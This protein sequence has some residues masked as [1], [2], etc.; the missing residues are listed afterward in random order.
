MSQIIT[1]NFTH[2]AKGDTELFS[3][4]SL[5]SQ[6]KLCRNFL[7]IIDYKSSKEWFHPVN[8]QS[9]RNL[10]DNCTL[11]RTNSTIRIFKDKKC[12]VYIF[13][14][15]E[16]TFYFIRRA[17]QKFPKMEYLLMETDYLWK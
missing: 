9:I 2:I 16:E 1:P 17:L 8:T 10:F 7:F 3:G 6:L 12:L 4:R 5:K 14:T 13:D 15:L 11:R